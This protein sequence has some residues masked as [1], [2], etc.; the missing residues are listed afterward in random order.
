MAWTYDQII[1]EMHTKHDYAQ[2]YL[3]LAR[4]SIDDAQSHWNSNQDHLAIEDLITAVYNNNQAGEYIIW[5]YF[6]GYG[7][8]TNMI[9]TALDRNMACPF[10]TEAPGGEVNMDSIL[11]AMI[12]A[13]FDELLKFIGI[14]DAYRV[15]LW[16]EP[17]NAEFYAA[18]AR[19]FT[20]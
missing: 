6:W 14:V 18:L 1:T 8:S 4:Q 12:A 7:G 5:G 9:P 2:S 10:I 11:S 13:D 16:N 3:W 17:F 20:P 19:G 15:S